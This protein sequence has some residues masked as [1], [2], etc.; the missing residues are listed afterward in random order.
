MCPQIN[1]SLL[2]SVILILLI[3]SLLNSKLQYASCIWTDQMRNSR[4][5]VPQ[6]ENSIARDKIF[7]T[8]EY[9]PTSC[10][11]MSPWLPCNFMMINSESPKRGRVYT[12]T[13]YLYICVWTSTPLHAGLW[14]WVPGRAFALYNPIT[15]RNSSARQNIMELIELLLIWGQ[16]RGGKQ[17]SAALRGTENPPWVLVSDAVRVLQNMWEVDFEGTTPFPSSSK[18]AFSLSLQSKFI[19]A[20]CISTTT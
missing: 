5:N 20:T 13:L 16:T 3:K 7:L 9:T 4:W 6:K 17:S 19:P 15:K 12:W 10:E 18:P 11:Q 1:I 14:L 2:Q 8:D